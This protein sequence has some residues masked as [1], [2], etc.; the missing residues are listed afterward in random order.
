MARRFNIVT[1]Q[2]RLRY[3]L[4]QKIVMPEQQ[5]FLVKLFG[6]E[7]D[8]VYRPG[9]DNVVNALSMK[10]VSMMRM[11]LHCMQSVVQNGRCRIK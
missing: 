6:Y 9:K 3:M 11:S 5:K 1:H 7:Y 4:E 2:Q 10:E 8:I